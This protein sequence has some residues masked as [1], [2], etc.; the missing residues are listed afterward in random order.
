MQDVAILHPLFVLAA[1]TALVQALIPVTRVRAALRG[2]V[3]IDDF[4][5][6]ESARVPPAVSLANRNYMNL[7]EFPVLY[8]VGCLLAHVAAEV[9]PTMV[10]LAWTYVALRGLHSLIHLT[11]NG[12]AHRAFAFGASNGVLFALWVLTFLHLR[13]SG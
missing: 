2:M 5:L 6:G 11:Y 3:S 1:L 12:V 13:A 4:A 10:A 8:Y 9:T 7:L